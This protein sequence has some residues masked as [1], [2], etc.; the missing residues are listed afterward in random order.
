ML[1]TIGLPFFN[2]ERT[3]EATISSV[4]RQDYDDW[5][6][7]LVDDGSSD[8]SLEIARS[9][10]DVRIRV[11]S[12]DRNRGLVDRLNQITAEARGDLVARMD[13]DDLM[14]PNRLSTQVA[15]MMAE[16]DVDVC[17]GQAY[18]IDEH[19]RILGI[20]ARGQAAGLV[21]IVSGII[22]PTVM[23]RRAWMRANPYDARFVRG[24]DHELW[25]RTVRTGSFRKIE[26]PLLFYRDPG[27]L[28]LQ[29][30]LKSLR[31]ARRVYAMHG[32]T[33]YGTAGAWRRV[34]R[35]YVREALYRTA[36]LLGQEHRLLARRNEALSPA[37][38]AAAEAV[39]ASITATT[40][41]E[42]PYA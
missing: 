40:T 18:V 31:T 38:R 41:P 8:R 13:S 4:L 23:A 35:T 7:L 34:T 14:M 12:D 10:D 17:Y 16:P 26:R 27:V 25:S 6:L 22:H 37:E 9:F 21:G 19:D 24:E 2:A 32:A 3:L 5:E 33:L 15:T 30:Y 42:A 11:R 36:H 20:R 39:L 28:R 1:V 29:P